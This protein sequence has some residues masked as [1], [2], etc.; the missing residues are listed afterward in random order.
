MNKKVQMFLLSSFLLFQ[1][2]RCLAVVGWELPATDLSDNNLISAFPQVGI[3]SAGNA[4]A[5]WQKWVGESTYAVQSR[6]YDSSA[7]LWLT[8]TQLTPPA[9]NQLKPQIAMNPAGNAIAVWERKD[10]VT[11][12]DT[13]QAARYTATSGWLPTTIDLS[14]NTQ[15]ASDPQIAIDEAGNAIA[16]WDRNSV[17]QARRYDVNTDSWSA[18]TNLSTVL[19]NVAQIAMDPSGNGIAVWIGLVGINNIIQT[20]R[21]GFFSDSWS[22]ATNLST[23]GQNADEAQIAMDTTSNGIAIWKRN[24]GA[25]FIIQTKRYDSETGLWSAT[26]NLSAA[27]Q[28]GISPQITMNPTGNGIAVW[29]RSDGANYIIQTKRYDATTDTWS[30]L[31]TDLSIAGQDATRPQIDTN[32]DGDAIT[33]WQRWDGSNWIIQ[34][35]NYEVTKN[36]WS[37][38]TTDLSATG[39]SSSRAQIA[40]NAAGKAVSVW[41]R[42]DDDT[43]NEVIQAALYFPPIPPTP[44]PPL[45]APTNLTAIKKCLRFPTQTDLIHCLTWD[46]V[47]N[48]TKYR[49]YVD[50]SASQQILDIADDENVASKFDINLG[51]KIAETTNECIEIRK[52]CSGTQITYYVVGVDDDGNNGQAASVTI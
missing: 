46:T 12:K 10:D 42:E 6:T 52:R 39:K 19:A 40:V 36:E 1:S 20:K 4:I 3:D 22:A 24:N 14:D 30:A 16:V 27:G 9:T 35:K 44:T 7:D 34:T 17:I 37:D 47:E 32:D 11:G 8:T 38:I 48:A 15:D 43:G 29:Y 21:Y 5:I 26:T 45:A 49:I 33:V 31:A 18:T 41:Q 23:T 28:N 51:V 25:N 2:F 13:I 50:A